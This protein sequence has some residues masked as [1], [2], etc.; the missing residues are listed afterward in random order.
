VLCFNH[1]T[2]FCTEN[3]GASA[4]NV[5]SG[6]VSSAGGERRTSASGNAGE[7]QRG[8]AARS[9]R[10]G[11]GARADFYSPGSLLNVDFNHASPLT[12]GLPETIAVWSEQSPAFTTDKEVVATYPER[13]ILAS[14][15]LLGG[16]LIANKAAIVD[17][18]TGSGHIV[19]FGMRPQYRAQSYQAFKLF[20]NALVAYRQPAVQAS[21]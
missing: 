9:G 8:P 12:L 11:E 3:L 10:R 15:W 18:A 2:A 17:A 4:T 6:R 14:G 7:D 19:L 20:F 16:E 5:L 21:F 13:G 1:S